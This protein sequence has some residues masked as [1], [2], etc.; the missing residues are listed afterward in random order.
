MRVETITYVD[1]NGNTRTEDHY[2][3]L[4][5]AEALEMEMSTNGGFSER[6]KRIIAAQDTATLIT[7]FKDLIKKSYGRKSL[8]GRKFE[9]SEEIFNEFK[10]TEAY[11]TLFMKLAT[12]AKS[13]TEFVNGIAPKKKAD[14]TTPA[15]TPATAT[16]VVPMN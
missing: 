9:K 8:D 5:E 4:T 14:T 11:S 10:D 3:N 1:Y 7:I 12:D 16:N 15:T 2:F 13:A 6:I